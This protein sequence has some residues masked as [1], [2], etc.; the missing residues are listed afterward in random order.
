MRMSEPLHFGI[1]VGCSRVKP[2]GLADGRRVHVGNLLIDSLF[3]F[4]L[5][6]GWLAGR[7]GGSRRVRE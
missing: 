4:P 1:S 5:V 2:D 6:A 3:F 7:L